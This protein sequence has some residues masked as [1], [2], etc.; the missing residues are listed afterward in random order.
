MLEWLV[1]KSRGRPPSRRKPTKRRPA[2]P[3]WQAGVLRECE[4]LL[5]RQLPRTQAELYASDVLGEVAGQRRTLDER[6]LVAT[7]VAD[8]AAYADRRRT[9]AAAA[10]VASLATVR[11]D[12]VLQRALDDWAR[13]VVA[14]VPWTTAPPLLPVSA[15]VLRDAYND[16]CTWMLQYDD[17]VLAAQTERVMDGAVVSATLLKPGGDAAVVESQP[18]GPNA[19]H[20][21]RTV[22][23]VVAVLREAQKHTDRWWPPH[24]DADYLRTAALMAARLRATGV[25]ARKTEFE[26]LPDEQRQAMLD[27]FFAAVGLPDDEV[28]RELADLCVAFGDGWMSGGPLMWSPALVERF[29]LDWVPR[30]TVLDDER[31][32]LVPSVTYAFVGWA[33]VE[34]GLDHD[35][36]AAAA[37]VALERQDDFTQLYDETERGP[38]TQVVQYLQDQGI[39]LTDQEAVQRGVGMWNAEQNARMLLRDD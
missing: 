16:A 39:D 26:P 19:V 8:L 9:P 18:Y 36:A 25:P 6:D 22:D 24:D 12:D 38:A 15:S 28:T 37:T 31:R 29:L 27:R 20:E 3:S 11:E 14:E 4:H 34:R 30:K 21:M 17:G 2:P 32:R 13:A 23:E 1:P 33:L 10:L 7:A 35:L 5:D